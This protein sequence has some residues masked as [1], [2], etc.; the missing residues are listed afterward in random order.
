METKKFQDLFSYESVREPTTSGENR[1]FIN[2]TILR[3]IGKYKQGDKVD[4]I[5]VQVTLY[6]WDTEDNFDEE[7][8]IL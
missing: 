5:G 2:C 8:I 3:T 1:V 6:I 7:Q 4:A